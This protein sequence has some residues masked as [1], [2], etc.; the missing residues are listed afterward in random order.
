MKKII[1]GIFKVT[2]ICL[3]LLLLAGGVAFF[4][5]RYYAS[6]VSGNTVEIPFNV[7]KG[8]SVGQIGEGLNQAGLIRH[9]LIFKLIT[10]EHHLAGKI[11]AG[12]FTLSQSMSVLDI[13]KALTQAHP[14]QIKATLLE[15]WR[16]EEI[17]STLAANLKSPESG[18]SAQEFLAK[19]AGLE[20][21]LFPDTYNFDPDTTTDEVVATLTSRFDQVVKQLPPS[22]RDLNSI[23]IMASLIE[24]EARDT[25]RPVIAGILWKRLDADW[26]LQ[27]DATLQYAKGFDK[28][29]N[30]WWTPPLAADRE[31]KSDFN[32]YTNT[33]LPPQPICNPGA[34]ALKAAANPVSSD[35]WYYIHAPDGKTYYAKTADEHT[36][37]VN[38][39]LR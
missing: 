34:G 20:G 39:Y 7:T 22:N 2:A 24:R 28:R 13:A 6:P 17:A 35:Y 1:T 11:Q 25:D 38:K 33:G 4:G 9:P 3:V 5:Y 14:D 36:A 27:V 15:G 23:L 32:T 29:T 18:F 10:L 12:K 30:S 21:K 31:V 8:Q 16:R 37:N 19:T 26:P